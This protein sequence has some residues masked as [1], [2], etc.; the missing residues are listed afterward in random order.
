MHSSSHL[1]CTCFFF[2]LSLSLALYFSLILL[3]HGYNTRLLYVFKS[4][5][6]AQNIIAIILFLVCTV[7]VNLVLR[8]TCFIF[9]PRSPF[10]LATGDLNSDSDRRSDMELMEGQAS[11][12]P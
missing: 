2:H 5:C 12:G 7:T 9:D 8:L 1:P 11:Q 4:F 10:S 3:Y 6:S